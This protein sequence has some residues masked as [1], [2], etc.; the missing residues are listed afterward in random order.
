MKHKSSTGINDILVF[1]LSIL[2]FAGPQFIFPACG[3]KTDGS[4]MICHRPHVIV[5]GIGAVLTLLGILR[6]FCSLKYKRL[7]SLLTLV[8]AL[9]AMVMPG[10]LFPLCRM[11]TMPCHAVF[12]PG[13]LFTGI[14]LVL[15]AGLDL[16]IGRRN[17]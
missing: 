4:W 3:P 15:A 7:L 12:K 14:L 9:V 10:H 17:H 16:I 5:T 13:V 6:L 2:L 8:M 11:A 1:L